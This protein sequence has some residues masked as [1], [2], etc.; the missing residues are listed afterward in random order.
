[1]LLNS[2][3]SHFDFGSV[4]KLYILFDPQANEQKCRFIV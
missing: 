2:I 1:M 4:Y 3:Q